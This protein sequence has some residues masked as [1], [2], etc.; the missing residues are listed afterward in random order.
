[1]LK[2]EF[3]SLK[4]RET[5]EVY[6]ARCSLYFFRLL[7]DVRR[8]LLVYRSPGEPRKFHISFILIYILNRALE[9][10]CRMYEAS[11][12]AA[13]SFLTFSSV[14]LGVFGSTR[15]VSVQRGRSDCV[16]EGGVS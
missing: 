15:G 1:V 13:L 7:S 6:E 14:K 4:D 10:N 11:S 16:I 5:K 8:G 9:S 12:I 3:S 2:I